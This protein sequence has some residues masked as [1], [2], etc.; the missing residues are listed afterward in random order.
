MGTPH[1]SFTRLRFIAL[2]A[3]ASATFGCAEDSTTAPASQ[4]TAATTPPVI[5]EH[6]LSPDG[7]ALI[8]PGHTRIPIN[9]K[10]VVGYVDAATPNGAYIDLSGWIAL[11]DFSAPAKTA[12]A[13]AGKRSMAVVPTVDRPDVVDGYDQPGLLHTGY[14]M[15]IP[16][17]S[18]DC[19]APHQ[20]LKTY[21]VTQNAAAPLEWLSNVG[22]IIRDA[23]RDR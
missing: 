1:L 9:P 21:A 16:I 17:K 19:S 22:Q 13:I 14:G 5:N 15:S 8:G 4:S 23:C 20:D 11:A 18:L 6:R 12:V 2:V 3:L 10:K 7:K